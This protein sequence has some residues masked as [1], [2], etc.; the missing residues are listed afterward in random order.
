MKH[1]SLLLRRLFPAS[2]F[3]PPAADPKVAFEVLSSTSDGTVQVRFPCRT[4]SYRIEPEAVAFALIY[5][6][7]DKVMRYV[8]FHGDLRKEFGGNI[9]LWTVPVN[10]RRDDDLMKE[11]ADDARALLKA[12]RD[13]VE[14]RSLDDEPLTEDP[15]PAASHSWARKVEEDPGRPTLVREGRFIAGGMMNWEGKQGQ[16]G[17]PSYAVVISRSD[18]SEEKLFGSD[19]NRVVREEG[20]Q[21]GDLVRLSKYPKQ[22][23]KVGNRTV[24]KNIW[25]CER[26]NEESGHADTSAH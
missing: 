21:A 2:A 14:L 24:Q 3:P 17:K 10:G 5:R 6:D 12:M 4:R 11:C 22:S 15:Q 9:R 18:G 1:I 16:R 26:L 23:V 7:F 8:E 19:L 13:P 25:T 20:L